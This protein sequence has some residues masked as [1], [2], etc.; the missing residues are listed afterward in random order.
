[1]ISNKRLGGIRVLIVDR[2]H[3][4]CEGVTQE[5]VTHPDI[6]V[7][8][9]AATVDAAVG[10]VTRLE[11][12]VVVIDAGISAG[13]C[14]D[15]CSRIKSL[16]PHTLCVVHTTTAGTQCHDS[17]ADAVVLK[18]LLGHQLAD[19]IRLVAGNPRRVES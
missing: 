9:Q 4:V 10:A 3:S 17:G 2:D 15:L 11:P 7:V 1:M 12:D 13:G 5:L 14:A 6:R 19:T 16:S 18:Q 8:A